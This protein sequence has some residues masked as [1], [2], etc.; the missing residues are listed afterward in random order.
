MPADGDYSCAVKCVQDVAAGFGIDRACGD[1]ASGMGGNRPE[2]SLAEVDSYIQGELGLHTLPLRG[3]LGTLSATLKDG[4]AIAHAD[5]GVKSSGHFFVVRRSADDLILSDPP[6]KLVY[7]G[8]FTHAGKLRGIERTHG[9]S[10]AYLVVSQD[11]L[12]IS[13]ISSDAGSFPVP[14]WILGVMFAFAA[15]FL[16]MCAYKKA[17]RRKAADSGETV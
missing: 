2:H 4:V 5:I 3:E 15:A 1:I 16:L 10:G 11:P 6:R 17:F 8:A 9:F 14:A 12:D 7:T 13:L